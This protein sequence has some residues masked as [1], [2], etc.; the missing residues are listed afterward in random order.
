MTP[1]GSQGVHGDI[2]A[3]YRFGGFVAENDAVLGGPYDLEEL[4]GI[5]GNVVRAPVVPNAGK[6]QAFEALGF[7][8]GAKTLGEGCFSCFGSPSYKAMHPGLGLLW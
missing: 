2:V 4:V 1:T 6:D 8:A 7:E 3:T 5:I